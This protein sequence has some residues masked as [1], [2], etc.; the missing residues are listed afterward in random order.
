V[1]GSAVWAG[2]DPILLGVRAAHHSPNRGR[3]RLEAAGSCSSIIEQEKFNIY[4]ISPGPEANQKVKAVFKKQ[5]GPSIQRLTICA[6]DEQG[7]V[8][9]VVARL[10]CNDVSWIEELELPPWP[11]GTLGY[12]FQRCLPNGWQPFGQT[13]LEGAS[14]PDPGGP[15]VPDPQ[16]DGSIAVTIQAQPGGIRPSASPKRRSHGRHDALQLPAELW[17]NV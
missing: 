17:R 10:V 1:P 4:W 14:V 8:Q 16:P 13:T 6:A 11:G 7:N 3:T 5:P 15:V 2:P 12:E 9:Q